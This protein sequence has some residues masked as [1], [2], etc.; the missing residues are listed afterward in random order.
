MISFWLVVEEKEGPVIGG[1]SYAQTEADVYG[2]WPMVLPSSSSSD[3]EYGETST[4]A[5][6]RREAEVV[7]DDW[8]DDD[9]EPEPEVPSEGVNKKIWEEADRKVPAPMPLVSSSSR[10]GAA[11]P[12]AAFQPTMKI[13]KRPQ[14]NSNPNSSPGTPSPMG[15]M[16]A[17]ASTESF[18]EREARYQA[19]RNRI[20]GEG[21][22]SPNSNA[23][24]TTSLPTSSISRED[25]LRASSTKSP[26]ATVVTRNPRGPENLSGESSGSNRG[27]EGRRTRLQPPHN[28]NSTAAIEDSRDVH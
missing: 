23:S 25:R 1:P 8:E 10:S 2:N 19:A 27:F 15:G 24:S 13:L 11:P 6:R 16:S 18:Q 12:P 9:D 20:F 21:A 26:P 22:S 4:T 14:P 5:A 7:R 17:S 3:W 28:T